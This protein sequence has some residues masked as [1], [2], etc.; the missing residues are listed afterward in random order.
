MPLGTEVD[1]GPGDIVRW[2]PSSPLKGTQPPTFR[3]MSIVAKRSP[4]SATAQLLVMGMGETD[5]QTDRQ[6]KDRGSLNAS[7]FVAGNSKGVTSEQCWPALLRY[8]SAPIHTT[9]H[10][11][12]RYGILVK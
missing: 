8:K 9:R 10:K 12:I 4:I 3:P 2:G 1:L 11:T 6:R 5:E 7:I